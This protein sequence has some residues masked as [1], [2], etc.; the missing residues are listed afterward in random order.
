MENSFD[1]DWSYE[2]IS[3]LGSLLGFQVLYARI[4]CLTLN[5]CFLGLRRRRSNS[6]Y[7]SPVLLSLSSLVCSILS[8]FLI[9]PR[10]VISSND[11]LPSCHRSP[12]RRRSPARLTDLTIVSKPVT[13]ST[14]YSDGR[15]LHPSTFLSLY[16]QYF[17]RLFDFLPYMFF[18]L[19]DY[20]TRTHYQFSAG[21]VNKF[22]SKTEELI[23]TPT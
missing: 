10:S 17:Y 13:S 21:L 3:K 22:S 4:P 15:Y 1:K 9:F 18:L 12:S 19:A 5:H 11:I 7:A 20:G 8:T 6:P 16:L 2:G 14:T 23:S